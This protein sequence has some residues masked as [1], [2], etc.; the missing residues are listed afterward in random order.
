MNEKDYFRCSMFYMRKF[1]GW[2]E[3]ILFAILFA[4]ALS[5]YF[6]MD[7][8]IILI[9]FGVTLALALVAVVFYVFTTKATFKH[10]YV[11]GNISK[12]SLVF[13]ENTYT[14]ESYNEIGEPLYSETY[15]YTRMEK[16]AMRPN[17]IYLY[18]SGSIIYYIKPEDVTEGD[19]SELRLFLI[20]HIDPMA[21]KMKGRVKQYPNYPWSEKRKDNDPN[22]KK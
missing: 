12:I 9:M 11:K 17:M 15:P 10:E 7:S 20:D 22:N 16:A 4:A 6:V 1:I 3:I 19:Y 14:V 21:F 8:A 5:F 13:T 2:R 18:P